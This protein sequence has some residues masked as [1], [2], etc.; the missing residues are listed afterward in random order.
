MSTLSLSELK[1][2]NEFYKKGSIIPQR[3]LKTERKK[4]HHVLFG[5][6]TWIVPTKSG[7][8]CI[9]DTGKHGSAVSISGLKNASLQGS[10]YGGCTHWLGN[11]YQTAEQHETTV[12]EVLAKMEKTS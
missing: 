10:P 5:S 4:K 11:T 2:R 3:V 9:C 1:A 12:L 6:D 8:L 7:Y